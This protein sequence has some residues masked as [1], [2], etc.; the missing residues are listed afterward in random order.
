MNDYPINLQ[1]ELANHLR[2]KRMHGYK[3]PRIGVYYPTTL[4]QSCTRSQWNFYMMAM[5]EG[6]FPDAFLLK[7]QEGTAWHELMEGVR[8]WDSVEGPARKRIKLEDGTWITIRGRYDAVRGYTVYDFKRVEWV[9][10]RKAKFDHILQL[11][12]Y[13]ECLG[14]PKGVL[15]YIGYKNGE[16]GIHE[17][18]HVLSDWHTQHLI[19]RAITL[20]MHLVNNAP[21]VCSCRTKFH[22]IEWANYLRDKEREKG[23]GAKKK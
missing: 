6:K 2:K 3:L 1:D 21:P 12:F 23:R 14:K 4:I 11:N 9:P 20:H 16:F 18:Y 7:T 15:A 19:N 5:R 8:I 17:Y 13:M 10:Y 22:E